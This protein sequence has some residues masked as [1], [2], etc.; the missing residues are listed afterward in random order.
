MGGGDAH[1]A[2]TPHQPA[3]NASI[4]FAGS[5]AYP[6]R[7]RMGATTTRTFVVG[8]TVDTHGSLLAHAI[9]EPPL[10]TS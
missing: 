1:A 10:V 3:K 7:F 5:E 4:K 9:N 6:K 8:M 2:K